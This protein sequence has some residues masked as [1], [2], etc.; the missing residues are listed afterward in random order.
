M[1]KQYE[2][3]T[4]IEVK[5]GIK[6]QTIKGKFGTNWW[7][8]R[9]IEA[10]ESFHDGARLQRGRNYARRGQVIS[11]DIKKGR[12]CSKVQGS[13]EKPYSVEIEFDTFSPTIWQQIIES[14]S[15]QAIYVAKLL[16]GKMP[17]DIEEVFKHAKFSLLPHSHDELHTDCSCPDWSN[18]CKHVA[19]VYY[20]L[21]EEFDRDP[22]L[23]FKLR[24]MDQKSFMH[25]LEDHSIPILEKSKQEEEESGAPLPSDPHVFWHH[26]KIPD[27]SDTGEVKPPEQDGALIKGLGKFSFWRG[28]KPLESV[29]I[30]IY[31]ETSKMILDTLTDDF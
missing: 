19:A 5:G 25:L 4:P 17:E 31:Q 28:K 16:A 1:W 14:L 15:S 3:T 9:W 2:R 23:I 21:G 22:F 26:E 6:A 24:G 30:T 18:P 12:V 10:L 27:S 13:R 8:K 29:L 20:L 11:I 7:S